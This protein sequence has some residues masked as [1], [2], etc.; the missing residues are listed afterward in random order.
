M[1]KRAAL[2]KDVEY[3]LAK[4]RGAG[5]AGTDFEE[6]PGLA[7]GELAVIIEQGQLTVGQ[8]VDGAQVAGLVDLYEEAH[9]LAV[10]VKEILIAF[11]GATGDG[12]HSV[13]FA[14]CRR[15]S[16]M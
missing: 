7:G 9:S 3:F 11:V 4:R 5:E 14:T 15:L 12:Q 13:G 6:T 16:G 10:A 2:G 8:T 1:G